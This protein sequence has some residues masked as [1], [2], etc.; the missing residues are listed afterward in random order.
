MKKLILASIV[1]SIGNLL[2]SQSGS[3]YFQDGTSIKFT[4]IQASIMWDRNGVG[5][6]VDGTYVEYQNSIQVVPWDKI[7]SFEIVSCIP[8]SFD[9]PT[10]HPK[11]TIRCIT[12][13]GITTSAVVY[14]DAINVYRM[15]ELTGELAIQIYKVV[16]ADKLNLKQII[17]D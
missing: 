15:N 3:L 2:F 4:K 7:S 1:F 9:F 17:M 10:P 11:A 6:A 12:K 8:K 13:T 16:V 14:F 5:G